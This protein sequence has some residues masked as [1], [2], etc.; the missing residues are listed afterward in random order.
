MVQRRQRAGRQRQGSRKNQGTPRAQAEL[1]E[2]DP[3]AGNRDLAGSGPG[4]PDN[5][6]PRS[7]LRYLPTI[8]DVL[9][10]LPP[11]KFTPDGISLL[12]VLRGQRNRKRPQPILFESAGQPRRSTTASSWSR[13]GGARRTKP[14]GRPRPSCSTCWPIPTRP[15]TWRQIIPV[16]SK[17]SP[18]K[19]TPGRPRAGPVR[20]GMPPAERRSGIILTFP[21]FPR[22]FKPLTYRVFP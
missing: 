14:P 8:L 20:P 13:S 10:V 19:S 2:G 9:G 17:N 11:R 7:D 6:Q 21:N 1:Y 4:R 12:P 22:P 5:R 3:R 18:P 16:W 15:P